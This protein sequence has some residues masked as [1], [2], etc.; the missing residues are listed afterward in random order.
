MTSMISRLAL[1]SE[2]GWGAAFRIDGLV[3]VYQQSLF[4]L[5]CKGIPYESKDLKL[6]YCLGS[7][8]VTCHFAIRTLTELL[9]IMQVPYFL[10][11]DQVRWLLPHDVSTIF[12]AQWKS[13]ITSVL[14]NISVDY[15]IQ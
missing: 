9:D 8:V 1:S 12:Y 6:G 13:H 7:E 3:Q 5:L 15:C 10:D 2:P 11:D 4:W 14:T